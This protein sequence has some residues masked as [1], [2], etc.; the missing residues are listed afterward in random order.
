M[1]EC[2]ARGRRGRFRVSLHGAES[3]FWMYLVRLEGG[4]NWWLPGMEVQILEGSDP[5]ESV[6][7]R[8]NVWCND[9]SEFVDFKIV[10]SPVG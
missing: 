6:R 10:V 1:I 4:Q 2:S 8:C 3:R 7:L 9:M 5:F